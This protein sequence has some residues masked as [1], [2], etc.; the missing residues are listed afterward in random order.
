VGGG[1]PPAFTGGGVTFAGVVVVVVV[2]VALAGAGDVGADAFG[3]VVLDGG[4][5]LALGVDVGDAVA[6]L[7]TFLVDLQ[8]LF[9]TSHLFTSTSLLSVPA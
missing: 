9:R 3:V 6:E 1:G 7:V 4:W 8:D 2:V 5:V